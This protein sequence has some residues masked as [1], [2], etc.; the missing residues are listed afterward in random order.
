MSSDGS[1]DHSLTESASNTGL[2]LRPCF[3]T[4]S[5]EHLSRVKWGP[6]ERTTPAMTWAQVTVDGAHGQAPPRKQG[7][8]QMAR[9]PS[10]AVPNSPRPGN[11]I[12]RNRSDIVT[13]L[14]SDT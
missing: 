2:D 14:P 4:G 11:N 12:P 7:A 6:R 10:P 13:R 3:H 1:T 8:S 9:T 5:L